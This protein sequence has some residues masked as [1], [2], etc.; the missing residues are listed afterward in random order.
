MY[1]IVGIDPGKTSAIAAVDL[2]GRLVHSAHMRFGGMDWLVR[3][4]QSSGTPAVVASDRPDVSPA[5]RKINAAFNARLFYPNRELTS[6]EKREIS[7]GVELKDPHERDAYAAAIK[8]YRAY[9]NKFKQAEHIARLMS[10][11]EVDRIKLKVVNKY[12]ISEAITEKKAN[13]R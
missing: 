13:R 11:A 10:A 1:T 6:D 2:N 12:S 4:A 8:A 7:K 3:E 9:A 5:V